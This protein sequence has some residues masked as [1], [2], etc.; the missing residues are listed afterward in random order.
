MKDDGITLAALHVL[1]SFFEV[2]YDL[3]RDGQPTLDAHVDV[4]YVDF[5]E[6]FITEVVDADA[7]L[8]YRNDW[9]AIFLRMLTIH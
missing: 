6:H 5:W 3:H 2:Q 4:V 1:K 8:G 9:Q 7:R